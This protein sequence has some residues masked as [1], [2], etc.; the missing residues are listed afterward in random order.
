[1]LTLN[2][3]IG[4]AT[5]SENGYK[6]RIDIWDGNVLAAFTSDRE[7]EDGKKDRILWG[8]LYSTDQAKS[9][10]EHYKKKGT[11]LFGAENVS[12][13]MN[14]YFPKA[15]EVVEVLTRTFGYKVECYYEKKV[16]QNLGEIREGCALPL[17][18]VELNKKMKLMKTIT[19]SSDDICII[20][21]ALLD[22][23]MNIKNSAK[24]CGITLSSQTLNKLAVMQGIV[25]KI[26][27]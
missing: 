3:K 9:M 20:T 4:E 8:F 17:L 10:A 2:S 5:L 19:L 14:L 16:E 15:K 27:D 18:N 11:R 13:K 23:A 22:K 1:M 12:I 24:I 6:E 26:N 21:L 25:D 7:T